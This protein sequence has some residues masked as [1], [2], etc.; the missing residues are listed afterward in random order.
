MRYTSNAQWDLKVYRGMYGDGI[1]TDEHR[2]YEEAAG[3][4]RL[5]ERE[6][7][8]GMGADFPLRTWVEEVK[9]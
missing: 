8:G 2:T 1:T 5:L 4:C 9:H 3:V 6:G 7:F